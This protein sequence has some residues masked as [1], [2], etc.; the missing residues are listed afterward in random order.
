MFCY[1]WK[2]Q[3]GTLLLLLFRQYVS[4]KT[5]SQTTATVHSLSEQY[6]SQQTNSMTQFFVKRWQSF[7]WS[8][9]TLLF[10]NETSSGAENKI[11]GVGGKSLWDGDGA[12]CWLPETY[13]TI[14]GNTHPHVWRAKHEPLRVLRLANKTSHSRF[15]PWIKCTWICAQ[16]RR[17]QE[18]PCILLFSQ[19]PKIVFIQCPSTDPLQDNPL[20]ASSKP[21]HPSHPFIYYLHIRTK[22]PKAVSSFHTNFESLP[23]TLYVRLISS[24]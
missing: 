1:T 19:I 22:Y 20:Q 23:Y 11:L 4:V 13:A 6:N 12:L 3:Q 10:L 24:S 9:N 17:G 2:V 5:K 21:P 8:R 14:I 16:L 7:S 18:M 15:T